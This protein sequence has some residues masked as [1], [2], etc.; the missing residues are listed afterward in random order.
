MLNFKER[1]KYVR[2]NTD[3]EKRIQ[4]MLICFNVIV[5]SALI[6]LLILKIYD[7]THSRKISGVELV[8]SGTVDKQLNDSMSSL[9]ISMLEGWSYQLDKNTVFTF[10]KDGAYSGFFDKDN[11]SI[12]EG[13]YD[14]T[15]DENGVYY[16]NI[17]FKMKSVSYEILLDGSDI[18]LQFPGASE[19]FVLSGENGSVIIEKGTD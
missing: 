19:P 18:L 12:K 15:V 13:S 3:K 5:I 2:E 11:K 8:D 7:K 10:K 17:N 6:C 9:Y 16:L 1:M 14:V 4:T